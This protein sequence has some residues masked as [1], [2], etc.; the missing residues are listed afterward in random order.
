MG[1]HGPAPTADNDPEAAITTGEFVPTADSVPPFRS[2][3]LILDD[4]RAVGLSEPV[5]PQPLHY[6]R[7][8]SRRSGRRWAVPVPVPLQSSWGIVGAKL[9]AIT[10][11]VVAVVVFGQAL[12][13]LAG[14]SATPDSG[15]PDETSIGVDGTA[16]GLR[17]DV[18]HDR[19]S[20]AR[21]TGEMA[22]DDGQPEPAGPT[23]AG[24]GRSPRR[25]PPADLNA[26]Y[27]PRGE[28][29]TAVPVA[30]DADLSTSATRAE[31]TTTPSSTTSTTSTTIPTSSS[32]TATAGHSTAGASP[33]TVVEPRLVPSSSSSTSVPAD[34]EIEPSTSPL[35]RP[36][37]TQPPVTRS[38]VTQPL[39]TRPPVTASRP[40]VTA[41][42]PTLPPPLRT[43][44]PVADTPGAKRSTP[45]VTR[46]SAGKERSSKVRST[47]KPDSP[48]AEKS[49]RP[50][51]GRSG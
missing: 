46:P 3:R 22:Y 45:A 9:G 31:S 23:T 34:T 2:S 50:E 25:P 35:T 26:G 29:R 41:P 19:R 43:P 51:R 28:S 20:R 37:V 4:G 5:G 27:R 11:A 33:V 49:K 32:S 47:K 30:T 44:P 24:S 15:P 16:D 39:V 17:D 36:P 13:D 42:S 14:E 12:A 1:D 8:P 18:D 48:A 21:T 38:P 40:P 10:V 6:R 7:P